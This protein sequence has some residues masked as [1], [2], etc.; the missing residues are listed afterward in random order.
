MFHIRSSILAIAALAS[1]LALAACGRPTAAQT[2]D[3]TG[4]MPPL[5]FHMTR[6]NDGMSVDAEDYRGKVVVLYFGYTHCPDECPATLANIATVFKRLGPR[7]N[8]V[9]MLFVS[10]DPVRDTPTLLKSYV[11]AFAPEIDGL[12]GSDD[13]VAALARRY[14]VLYTVTPA[15]PGHPY[16]VTHSASV[17]VFDK[18]GAARLVRMS[19]DNTNALAQELSLLLSA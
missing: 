4:V 9:R 7:A 13:D 5:A 15:S 16:T 1:T 14:R 12:R 6:V 11:Q 18:T 8:G 3:I 10:V 19:T 2:T 17:F